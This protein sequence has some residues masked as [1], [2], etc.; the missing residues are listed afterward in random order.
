MLLVPKVIPENAE[1]STIGSN[2][3][4]VALESAGGAPS[5]SV[6]ARVSAGVAAESAGS[7]A[8]V[9]R[10]VPSLPQAARMTNRR[11]LPEP[12]RRTLQ[13]GVDKPIMSAASPF[14]EN[15]DSLT[16]T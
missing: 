1:P 8:S 7:V 3:S 6:V 13:F 16:V 5:E 2:V 4:P 12:L 10:L 9:E 14:F 15:I 11:R